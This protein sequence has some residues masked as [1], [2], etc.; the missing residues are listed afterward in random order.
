MSNI[1]KAVTELFRNREQ[2]VVLGLTGRT[3]SG[4]STAARLLGKNFD[5]LN[6]PKPEV[7]K[8]M[9]NEERKYRILY[10]Y[11]KENWQ[12][13]YWISM[14]DVITS[15]ILEVPF[16]EFA[17][18]VD[19]TL[20]IYG[21]P[22]NV[23]TYLEHTI[24]SKYLELHNRWKNLACL[25]EGE[26]IEEKREFYTQDLPDFTDKLKDALNKLSHN[27]DLKIYQLAGSNIRSSGKATDNHFDSVHASAIA[28]RTNELIKLLRGP[29]KE[30][31]EGFF[32]VIDAI[33][34][35]FE[36]F[37][38]RERYSAFYLLSI[39]TPNEVRIKRLHEYLNL[40]QEQIKEIDEK[41]Y[42]KRLAGHKRFVSQDIQKCIE[43]SDIHVNNPEEF[44][45]NPNQLKRQLVWYVALMLHPGL[46]IPT[47]TERAM[48]IA[49]S[50]KLNSG[51]I[52]R[53]VGAVIT[54]EHHSVKAVGWNSTPEGQVP[55]VLRDVRDL[56]RHEDTE[57]F[58]SY[59]KKDKDFQAHLRSVYQDSIKKDKLKVLDGRNISFCFKDVQNSLDQEKNQVHTRSLHAEENA[60]L[61]ITKYGG[62]GIRGGYLFTTASPCE[63][64]AKKA[65]QLGI[66]KIVYVDPYPGIANTHILGIGSQNTNL[67]LFSGAIGRAYH[68][69]YHPVFAY[70]DE[71]S[72]LLDLEMPSPKSNEELL[73]ENNSLRERIAQLEKGDTV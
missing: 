18:F 14:R 45:D 64:C 43:W 73:Q 42:P 50:A 10:D 35:P 1:S 36:A 19:K 48:Q 34:N 49:Y 32:V 66:R 72:M 20:H 15:F 57:A 38:F 3:G 54:D 40:N 37:F 53:Q 68:Q 5:D 6:P 61:Q 52:S 65:Y 63:L 21:E 51:C 47:G 70:K 24:G 56:L 22:I 55:C 2:F 41:E 23:L 69:L 46:V 26:N 31:K 58:S 44:P 60:F 30:S 11:A 33:R 8:D 17:G 25:L 27:H 9:P 4:C 12:P 62:E 67:E 29:I 16:D 39:N 71:L 7:N 59:E 28:Q 13:F